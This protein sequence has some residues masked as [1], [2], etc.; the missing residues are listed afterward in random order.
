MLALVVTLGAVAAGCSTGPALRSASAPEPPKWTT[1]SG[2]HKGGKRYFVGRSAGAASSDDGYELATNDALR[3]VVREL[4]ITVQ[5]DSSDVQ[6]EKDGEF[7]YAIQIRLTTQS[8]PIRLARVLRAKLYQEVWERPA[9]EFDSWVLLSVPESELARARRQI[10]GRVLLSW[11]CKADSGVDCQRSLLEPLAAVATA[12]GHSLIPEAVQPPP[13][14]DLA[15]LG[16]KREAAYVLSVTLEATFAEESHGEFYATGRGS[17]QVID[18]GDG[19][20][21]LSLDSGPNKGGEF[22]R[23]KAVAVTLDNIVKGLAEQLRSA[24]GF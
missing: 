9:V 22:S 4:G 18:T 15:A 5:E 12:G 8:R 14:T 7:S 23:E 6:R 1:R 19:K 2:G 17:I 10:A 11:S 20:A 16:V 3:G 21:V 24:T 13:G